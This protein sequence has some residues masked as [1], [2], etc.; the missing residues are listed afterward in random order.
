VAQL[1]QHQEKLEELNTQ[2]VII[3]FGTLPTVQKWMEENCVGFEVLL[4]RER[5]VY[6]AFGLDRS[7]W[8]SRNF[9][10]RWVYFKAW[11]AGEKSHDSYGD[12]TSQLGGDFI[13]NKDG[14]LKLVYPSHDPTDRP[15]LSDLLKVLNKLQ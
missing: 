7:F 9:K 8:R 3:S 15:P 1:C 5:T 13:I 11:L 2:V 4:D 14:I 6:Q 10:T 12:D